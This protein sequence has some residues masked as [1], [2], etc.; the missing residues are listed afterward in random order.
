MSASQIW[1]EFSGKVGIRG[2]E[3]NGTKQQGGGG[4]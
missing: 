4:M 2:R 3:A 1:K